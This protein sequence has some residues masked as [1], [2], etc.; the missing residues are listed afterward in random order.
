MQS[1]ADLTAENQRYVRVSGGLVRERRGPVVSLL[2]P[3]RTLVLFRGPECCVLGGGSLYGR[4]P[5]LSVTPAQDEQAITRID[6]T[7]PN[8]NGNTSWGWRLHHPLLWW[9]LDTG[10]THT[11]EAGPRPST[12]TV[13]RT[14]PQAWRITID[15]PTGRDRIDPR[16]PTGWW[17]FSATDMTW[18]ELTVSWSLRSGP[19]NATGHMTAR[20]STPAQPSQR[21]LPEVLAR[22]LGLRQ[23]YPTPTLTYIR[24]PPPGGSEGRT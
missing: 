15:R 21:P 10:T 14:A 19:R 6:V 5:A 3:P 7:L 17:Q 16:R 13:A 18:D 2:R 24:R 12:V 4:V 8:N 9:P 22:P 23:P 1:W 11:T 20:R